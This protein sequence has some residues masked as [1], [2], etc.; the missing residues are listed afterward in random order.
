[1]ALKRAIDR[2]FEVQA[3]SMECVAASGGSRWVNRSQAGGNEARFLNGHLNPDR[4]L[5]T[6]SKKENPPA[7]EGMPNAVPAMV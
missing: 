3:W 5:S 7:T 4:T 1:M 2:K 6:A